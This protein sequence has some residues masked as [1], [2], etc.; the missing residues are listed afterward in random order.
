M[1]DSGAAERV[2]QRFRQENKSFTATLYS[3]AAHLW[4]C[5]KEGGF[6]IMLFAQSFWELNETVTI[7]C[8]AQGWAKIYYMQ[9]WDPL[10]IYIRKLSPSHAVNISVS[11]LG[12]RLSRL[13]DGVAVS[14]GEGKGD[15]SEKASFPELYRLST[16]WE[17]L[18]DHCRPQRC[19]LNITRSQRCPRQEQVTLN[20]GY[21]NAE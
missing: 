3:A 16:S 11:W 6:V 7:K 1:W 13:Q 4:F 12:W 19:W 10:P 14:K 5:G 2:R 17:T 8:L 18:L 21:D 9:C 15:E 20:P